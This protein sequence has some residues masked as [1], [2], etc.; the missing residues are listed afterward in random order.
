MATR[1]FLYLEL[2]FLGSF[3]CVGN[4]TQGKLQ[5]HRQRRLGSLPESNSLPVRLKTHPPTPCGPGNSNSNVRYHGLPALVRYCLR[6]AV[7]PLGGIVAAHASGFPA[8]EAAFVP[9]HVPGLSEG[10]GQIL[11]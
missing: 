11:S 2:N 1:Y 10:H 6:R 9:L 4:L 5:K 3:I 7:V 8:R